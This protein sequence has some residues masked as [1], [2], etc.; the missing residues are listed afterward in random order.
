MNMTLTESVVRQHKISTIAII[1][2]SCGG[3]QSRFSRTASP[4][5]S[6]FSFFSLI[7]ISMET[8]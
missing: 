2:T 5:F 7:K 1:I 3:S 6:N 8:I 4:I